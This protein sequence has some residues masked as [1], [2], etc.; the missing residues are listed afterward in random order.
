M[1]NEK[2]CMRNRASQT[3]LT[4]LSTPILIPVNRSLL[5]AN[6][7]KYE[8]TSSAIEST[9]LVHATAAPTF[10]LSILDPSVHAVRGYAVG[11]ELPLGCKHSVQ[12]NNYW[13][14]HELNAELCTVS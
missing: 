12:K 6:S 14:H 1:R 7:L 5:A 11:R 13:S 3:L 8:T 9:A 4:A 10:P 2:D